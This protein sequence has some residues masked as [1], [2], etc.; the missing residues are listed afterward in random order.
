MIKLYKRSTTS[1]EYW[2]AWQHGSG[3]VIHT[4][5]VGAEDQATQR[6]L[7]PGASLDD[8]IATLANEQ[9]KRGFDE[10]DPDDH[11]VLIVQVP[12]DGAQPTP[13]EMDKRFEIEDALNQLLGWIGAGEVDGG[14]AGSGTMN[15]FALIVAVDPVVPRVLDWL[16]ETG[17][18]EIARVAS[19]GPGHEDE[20]VV[21]HPPNFEGDFDY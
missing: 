3:L 1:I 21:H 17:L 6:G 15:V 16:R 11:A 8:T 2:E 12:T 19:R 4:G 9:M 7:N 13:A 10:V 14:D 5:A 18:S 20:L